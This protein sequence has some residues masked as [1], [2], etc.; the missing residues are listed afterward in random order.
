MEIL[1]LKDFLGIATSL[2][3]LY[4]LSDNLVHK[5]VNHSVEVYL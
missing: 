2:R 4:Q 3:R 5:L 1:Y